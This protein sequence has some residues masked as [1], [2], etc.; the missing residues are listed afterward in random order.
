MKSIKISIVIV[1]FNDQQGFVKT[2]DS[3]SDQNYENLEL[4]VIDGASTDGSIDYIK[5]QKDKLDILV[6]EPDQ[7]IYDAMNKGMSLATGDWL[8]F[9]NAGDGFA[10]SQ[11]ISNLLSHGLNEP[12][13][14]GQSITYFGTIEKLRYAD[15]G[16][17]NPE[18]YLTKMPNHQAVFIAREIYISK[19]FDTQFKV[20]SDTIFLREVFSKYS[21]QY[22]PIV[23]SRFEL[24]GVSNY[25]GSF[26]NY[27]KVSREYQN[28]YNDRLM[29]VKHLFKYILQKFLS[30]RFY[31]LIY[32]KYL[33]K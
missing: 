25:Y 20:I 9:L 5:R 7:G 15:F 2:I 1:H 31:H 16:F 14:F 19:Q 22:V 21:Y 27:Q 30:K 8:C 29:P 26:K 23:I 24:G 18:W 10:D 11:V 3:I 28:L 6:S 12:V 33:L 13:I 4:I 17:S 32:I